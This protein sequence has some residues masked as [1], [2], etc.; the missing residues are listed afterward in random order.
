MRLR[1]KQIG[2]ATHCAKATA[3]PEHLLWRRSEKYDVVSRVV[4][5]TELLAAVVT[6]NEILHK[7][8]LPGALEVYL[9]AMRQRLRCR[10]I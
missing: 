4:L 8:H 3:S 6:V 2:N 10:G 5:M 1:D 9:V 7:I